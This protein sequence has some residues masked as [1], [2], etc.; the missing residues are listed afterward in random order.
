MKER[1][2]ENAHT[3]VPKYRFGIFHFK[4]RDITRSS[5]NRKNTKSIGRF[6]QRY[7]TRYTDYCIS[8][9]ADKKEC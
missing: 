1:K 5:T 6:F 8:C 9:R 2:K 4:S 7:V 3:I